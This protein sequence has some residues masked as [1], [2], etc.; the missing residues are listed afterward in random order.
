MKYFYYSA[1]L[2]D[3]SQSY[4][5]DEAVPIAQVEEA[6]EEGARGRLLSQIT[7]YKP[8]LALF[9]GEN[10]PVVYKLRE[11]FNLHF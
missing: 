1:A 8:I 2:L 7:K 11:Q 5:A 10:P 9:P 3:S 4:V 6:E